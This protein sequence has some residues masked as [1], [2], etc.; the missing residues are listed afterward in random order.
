MTRKLNVVFNKAL[1]K[2]TGAP[3]QF[4][5]CFKEL[6][7]EFCFVFTVYV[8]LKL[9]VEEMR[10]IWVYRRIYWR[11][12]CVC[13]YMLYM[14][15]AIFFYSYLPED[16]KR[17]AGKFN[18]CRTFHF[19]IWKFLHALRRKCLFFSLTYYWTELSELCQ[20]ITSTILLI[21]RAIPAKRVASRQTTSATLSTDQHT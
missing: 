15:L 14:C 17:F 16:N 7:T 10:Q 13:T 1:M 11:K 21:Y 5:I 3:T 20:N 9:H 18:F 2:F 12:K 19:G 6:L 8:L 4:P